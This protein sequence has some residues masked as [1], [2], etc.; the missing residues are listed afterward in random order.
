MKTCSCRSV[1]LLAFVSVVP[2]LIFHCSNGYT[3]LSRCF[4]LQYPMAS[5]AAQAVKI[6]L[7][8]QETWV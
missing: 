4:N 7:A 3:E 5:L 6:P 1:S 8:V 2:G